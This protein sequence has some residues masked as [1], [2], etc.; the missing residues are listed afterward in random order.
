MILAIDMGNSNV[1]IGVVKN[2]GEIFEERVKTE[3]DKTSFQYAADIFL[4]LQ[5]YGFS[6]EEFDGAIISSVVPS[7]TPVLS[8]AVNKILGKRPLIVNG[9][10]KMHVGLSGLADKT[11]LGAD[12]I[13]AAE[14]AYK[15]YKLPC[16]IVNMGTATTMTMVDKDG[17]FRG[18]VI[19]PGMKTSLNALTL[20]AA[21]LPDIRLDHPGSTIGFN[22]EECMRN[23]IIYGNA[24]QI[25]GITARME[26]EIGEPCTVVATGGMAKFCVSACR[27]KVTLDDKIIMT[28]LLS[29]YELNR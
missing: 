11:G 25:D 20:S 8:A 12:L 2:P 14:G 4:M 26:E 19:L 13:A 27:R 7:L 18:G 10:M 6:K 17:E 24:S 21:I 5:Y 9:D 28:G 29:L 23:G 1:K 15:S 16:I 3:Y 22:T